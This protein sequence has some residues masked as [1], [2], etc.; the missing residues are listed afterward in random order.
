M[1]VVTTITALTAEIQAAKQGRKQL[2]LC[3]RWAIYM[4]AI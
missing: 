2:V 1:K 4:R 3:R